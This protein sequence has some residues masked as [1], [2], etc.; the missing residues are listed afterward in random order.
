MTLGTIHISHAVKADDRLLDAGTHRVRLTG[1]PLRAAVGETPNLEQ[2]V[3][4]LQGDRVKAKAVA[5]IVPPD[6]IHQV[7]KEPVPEPGHAVWTC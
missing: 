3:E 5:S 7:A 1:E 6:Q 2:R 4:F